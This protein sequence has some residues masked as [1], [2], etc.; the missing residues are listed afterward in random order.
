MAYETSLKIAEV[1]TDIYKNEYVLPAIQRE[2]V[3]DTTQIENLFDSLMQDY[4][5]GTFLFWEISEESVGNYQFYKFLNQYNE[6]GSVHNE[7][8]NLKGVKGVTAV[9]DGQQRLTSLYIGLKGTY[10]Y[11]LKYKRK[12]N[13]S[14]YPKRKL[15]LNLVDSADTEDNSIKYDFKFKVPNKIHDADEEHWFEVG[16]I[17]TMKQPGDVMKYVRK[18]ISNKFTNKQEDFAIETLSKLYSVIYNESVLSYYKV[19]TND[20]DK[21]LNIFIRVNSGGTVL[22]YSDLLL[23]I[24]SAQW[25]NLDAREEIIEFVEEVNAIGGGFKINKDFVLKT[26]LV[27]SDFSNIAFKVDN[28]NKSNMAT[29]E[30]KWKE[31]T[32]AIKQ[33]VYLVSSFGYTGETLSSNNALIPIAY[34]LM[35]IGMPE[36]FVTS[37]KTK[38]NRDKIKKWLIMSLLKKAFSGQPDNVIRPIRRII[39]ENGKKDFP[40][41]AI[42]DEFKGKPKSIQFDNVDIDEY[43]LN[44]RYGEKETLYT[45]MLLYPS[46]DFSN[47]FHIDHIYPKSNFKKDYLEKQGVTEDELDSYIDA[48]NNIGNLQLLPAQL[49]EEKSNTDFN[50][51]FDKLYEQENEKNNYKKTHML[52]DME[53]TYENF[54]QFIEQRREIMKNELR[55]LL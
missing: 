50:V 20:L 23:S 25:K 47:R 27:L 36:D 55:A 21:V 1:V 2:F 42:I 16:D 3:W 41:G 54:L 53:Y 45:L 22:T 52:P 33:S 40:L 10:A 39:K 15:Y 9:L 24:A 48:V 34:Y 14:A 6:N 30:A 31:I 37:G 46:L 29:I 51:W 28:F 11:R 8:A 19:K 49:N 4:P 7:K 38:K 12:N 5:I 18:N 43:L 13:L 17:L 26:A 35:T 44:L 32:D